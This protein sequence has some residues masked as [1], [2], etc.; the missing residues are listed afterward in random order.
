ME[1]V[2]VPA[3]QHLLQPDVAPPDEPISL[4]NFVCI[5]SYTW[6][7]QRNPTIVVPGSPPRW[8]ERPFPIQVRFDNGIRMINENGYYMGGA[9]S[10]IPLFRA[11][12]SITDSRAVE[13]APALTTSQEDAHAPEQINWPSV[14]FVTDR[15]NLRKFLRW[16]RSLTP[17]AASLEVTP[18]SPDPDDTE[19]NANDADATSLSENTSSNPTGKPLLEPQWDDRKDFRIDLHLGGEKTVLMER[20]AP[21][22]RE[23]VVPPTGGCRD[24]F[25][26]EAVAHGPDCENG[27]GHYRIVQYDIG[28]LRM[29]VRWEVDS[30]IP[31]LE[32][33]SPSASTSS[34]SEPATPSDPSPPPVADSSA[35]AVIDIDRLA[36]WDNNDSGSRAAAWSVP[37]PAS[38]QAWDVTPS[39]VTLKSALEAAPSVANNDLR[40]AERDDSIDHSTSRDVPTSTM[41]DASCPIEQ[42]PNANGTD[43]AAAIAIW[44]TSADDASASAAAWGDSSPPGAPQKDT[45]S[46]YADATEGWDVPVN[47]GA[48]WDVPVN[49]SASWDVPTNDN[50]SWD[51]PTNDSASWD[52][53]TN[54]NASWD[55]GPSAGDTPAHAT[56]LKVIRAGTLLPQSAM[57]ELATRSAMFLDRTNIE[58]T[59]LQLFLTRSPVNLVAVHNRGSFDRVIRQELD[60]PELARFNECADVQ[61]SLAQLVALLREIQHIVQAR[62]NT[63][64]LSLVCE[65]GQLRVHSRVGDEDPLLTGELA[66]FL[67]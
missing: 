13:P 53:P 32:A 24:N 34:V 65:K 37:E 47:D 5:G 27:G 48:S 22:E 30:W 51:V 43:I 52:I 19:D 14:D 8:R 50:A 16:I 15:N 26:R 29:V 31:D 23:R 64:K 45:A 59:Y 7:K 66:R 6:Y 58:D 17:H 35:P 46:V 60:S 3:L 9:S 40:L 4:Q 12:D 56:E 20:W 1:G 21:F 41:E 62:G 33:L 18:A 28:G 36:C 25:L 44:D 61:R 2:L 42:V 49:D 38:T 10:F 54:D 55:V 11:V 63:G 67:A 39:T 57:L